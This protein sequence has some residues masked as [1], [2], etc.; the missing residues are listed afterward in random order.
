[1]ASPA[2]SATQPRT[3]LNRDRVLRAAVAL[4]DENG[5]GSLSMRLRQD[6]RTAAHR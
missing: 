4:A 5:I 2:K 6:E 3:P 1:M